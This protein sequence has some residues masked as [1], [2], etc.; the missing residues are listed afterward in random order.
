MRFLLLI[1][2]T[3]VLV[4][5]GGDVVKNEQNNKYEVWGF[6]PQVIPYSSIQE[7]EKYLK[8]ASSISNQ[9]TSILNQYKRTVSIEEAIQRAI[10]DLQKNPDVIAVDVVSNAIFIYLKKGEPVV[11]LL[12]AEYR[13]TPKTNQNR[14]KDK[15]ISSI[16]KEKLLANKNQL[17]KL[18]RV[19]P[20]G[21]H[22]ALIL[23]GFQKDF[24]ED[25]CPIKRSLE[26]A[27]Y[28]VDFVVDKEMC[29][30]SAT[31]FDKNIINYINSFDKYDVIYINTH[32]GINKKSGWNAFGT[33][34]EYNIN[35]TPSI[36]LLNFYKQPGVG[37]FSDGTLYVTSKYINHQYPKTDS[38]PNSYVHIDACHTGEALNNGKRPIAEAFISHGAAFYLS[39]DNTTQYNIQTKEFT[40][41]FINKLAQSGVSTEKAKESL[42]LHWT[43]KERR[44]CQNFKYG[45][46]KVE[47]EGVN[48]VA[49]SSKSVQNDRE[50]FMLVPFSY[51]I[52]SISPSSIVVGSS[53]NIYGTGFNNISQQ[54]ISLYSRDENRWYNNISLSYH[55]DSSLQVTIPRFVQPGEYELFIGDY[56]KLDAVNIYGFSINIIAEDIINSGTINGF[57]QDAITK[58]PIQNATVNV[59][60]DGNKILTKATSSSGEYEIVLSEGDYILNINAIAYI[61]E[62]IHVHVTYNE[63]TNI[64]R[65]R[66]IPEDRA[67]DGI[68]KG[69][70]YDAKDGSIIENVQLN[71]RKGINVKDGS[72]V[73]SMT[74]DLQGQYSVS[75]PAGN[76]TVEVNK[77]G[78][79]T[80][81]FD[82]LIIG[83]HTTDQQ[84][85]S[86]TPTIIS[87]EIRIVLSWGSLPGDLDSVLL[88]PQIDGAEYMV[89]WDKRG[90]EYS[91]PYCKL[92]IDRTDLN[93][94][95]TSKTEGPET[96]TIYKSF[97]GVYTYYVNNYSAKDSSSVQG[98]L[99]NSRAKVDIY[100]EEGLIKTFYV[101]NYGLGT[102]WKVF[103][104]DGS[105]GVITPVNIISENID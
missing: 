15:N 80:T 53:I 36:E 82:V 44:D 4:G 20:T 73:H 55:S 29:G 34:V 67:G 48:V 68:A 69:F 28:A 46:Q 56:S 7:A 93:T 16:N 11:V 41:P 13:N 58:N 9:F 6:V 60:K 35:N 101:P 18:R 43:I 38:L 47:T 65:L 89:Y 70:I 97:L 14:K 30:V 52:S 39:Y 27:G 40:T 61:P 51:V 88:T 92:D 49:I 71:F 75:L 33:G 23:S 54:V 96:I 26:N 50:G 94:E 59:Y 100:S 1:F 24:G 12:D 90:T 105:S 103:T 79:T 22:K 95:D 25:L 86:I 62:T 17:K 81:Y 63:I 37:M 98:S 45:C 85:V 74:S 102:F 19:S 2:L 31:T 10:N 78:Y 5:C 87:G 8:Q 66:Q 42:P 99:I 21:N 77:I 72:I 84:N 104:Y 64:S 76:Y 32:G 57:V 83:Q 3:I 91:A